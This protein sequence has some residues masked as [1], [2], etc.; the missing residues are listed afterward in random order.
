MMVLFTLIFMIPL[1]N[2]NIW[3]KLMSFFN[4]TF[5]FILKYSNTIMNFNVSLILGFDKISYFMVLLSLWVCSLMILASSKINKLDNFTIFFNLNMI[6]LMFSLMVVFSSLNLL[7]FYIFFEVSLIPVLFLIVGWGYQ[8]ERLA[9]GLYLIFYTLFFSL[10][11]M[12]GIFYL[13]NSCYSLMFFEFMSLD[14]CFLYFL[15]NMIFFVKIPMFGIHLWLP[16]AHVEAP[17]SGS[18]ILA[19]VMLKLGGYGLMRLMKV[20][21]KMGLCL[22]VYMISFALIGGVLVSLICFYQSDIKSLIAY[23]SVSHMS[24]VM[25]GIL[26]LNYLGYV[27]SLVLMIGHGLCSS[28]LFVLANVYYERLNT[29]SLYVVK[30][31]INL[32]PSVSLWMF[33]LSVCNM[34]SPPSLNLLGEIILY[35]SLVSYSYIIMV[36]LMVISFFS[37][38]YS[39]YLYSYTNHGKF[40][41]GIYSFN[42]GKLNE[43]LLLFLHWFPLNLLFLFSGNLFMI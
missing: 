32:I 11:M 33:M 21:Q 15:I 25:S 30:G 19:G 2:K 22:N 26:S 36:F 29:R 37:A 20:F 10:P 3:V 27:G 8:P 12:L 43:F 4:V 17:V 28:G 31:L 1:I 42:S 38:V 6:L 9:A 7:I 35:M 24:L 39:L 5:L 18:M 41:L 14:Y 16:K 23:S 40:S 34:S 13:L